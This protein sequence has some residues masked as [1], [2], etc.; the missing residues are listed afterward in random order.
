MCLSNLITD[1][2]DVISIEGGE[3]ALALATTKQRTYTGGSVNLDLDDMQ[4]G[5]ESVVEVLDNQ[6]EEPQQLPS[7]PPLSTLSLPSQCNAIAKPSLTASVGEE[8][9]TSD[10]DFSNLGLHYSLPSVNEQ[11]EN[12][13]EYEIPSNCDI[14]KDYFTFSANRDPSI[15][16]KNKE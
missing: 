3:E 8:M 14:V 2:D 10:I 13:L 12:R 9:T 7:L 6:G 11:K 1:N 15:K 5:G 16:S 4:D